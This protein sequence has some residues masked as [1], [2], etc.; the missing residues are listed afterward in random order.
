MIR[1]PRLALPHQPVDQAMVDYRAYYMIMINRDHRLRFG[2]ALA[3][4]GL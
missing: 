4:A 3:E 1:N 2:G